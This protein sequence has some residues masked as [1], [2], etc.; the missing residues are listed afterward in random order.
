MAKYTISLV[1]AFFW[2]KKRA[3]P[4]ISDTGAAPLAEQQPPA[5]AA[6][7]AYGGITVGLFVNTI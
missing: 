3:W 2:R 1:Q 4:G 7:Q 5:G 6:E